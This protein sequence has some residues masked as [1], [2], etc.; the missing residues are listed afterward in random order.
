MSF[1]N[2]SAAV[3]KSV[4]EKPEKASAPVAPMPASELAP[5]GAEP[6]IK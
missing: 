5:A 1:K 4:P 2:W 6:A 3:P